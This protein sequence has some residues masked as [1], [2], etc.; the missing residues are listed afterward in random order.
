ME[1]CKK[2]D[3]SHGSLDFQALDALKK[4]ESEEKYHH[5]LLK[6]SSSHKRVMYLLEQVR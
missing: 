1:V 2:I 3:L 6:S 5:G 4:V